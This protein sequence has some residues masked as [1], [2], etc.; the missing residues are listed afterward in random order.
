MDG[1]SELEISSTALE[2]S[3]PVPVTHVD[4]RATPKSSRASVDACVGEEELNAAPPIPSL[5]HFILGNFA[6]AMFLIS[7]IIFIVSFAVTW[8][9]VLRDAR[10]M[11]D[12]VLSDTTG[13]GLSFCFNKCALLTVVAAIAI[14]T[15][16]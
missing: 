5:V 3:N 13:V 12:Q 2:D 9:T 1:R 7:L 15:R 6:F 16:S 4:I 11:K 10:L 14:D 8:F